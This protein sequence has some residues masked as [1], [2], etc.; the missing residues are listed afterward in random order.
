MA[1]FPAVFG[2]SHCSSPLE[3]KTVIIPVPETTCPPANNDF[4]SVAFT[5]V[6]MKC[7]EKISVNMLKTEVSSPLRFAYKHW[8]NT[9][10]MV[11]NVTTT[12]R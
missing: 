10:D 5:S 9:A 3:K 4:R 2:Q 11:I 1:Y 8:L 6:L 7:F 12:F